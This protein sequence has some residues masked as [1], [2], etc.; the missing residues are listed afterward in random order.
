MP[1][2]TISLS[3]F[4][5]AEDRNLIAD[6]IHNAIVGV[7]FPQTDRFQKIHRLPPANFYTMNGIRI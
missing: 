6:G 7:G 3:N 1:L 2:V 5:S 4:W